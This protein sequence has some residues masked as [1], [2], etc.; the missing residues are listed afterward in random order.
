MNVFLLFWKY[1]SIYFAK[2]LIAKRVS[3]LCRDISETSN[4]L[5]L[6]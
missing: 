1:F 5:I 3:A 4:F 6:F 2:K